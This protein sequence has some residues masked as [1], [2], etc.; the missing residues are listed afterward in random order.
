MGTVFATE[1]PTNTVKTPVTPINTQ[2][3]ILH[4]FISPVREIGAYVARYVTFQEA[5]DAA[6]KLSSE[7]HCGVA[8][9]LCVGAWEF[10]QK[11]EQYENPSV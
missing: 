4:Y 6:Q 7:H 2:P 3:V 11:W 10:T 5:R 1:G 8:V 9:Y